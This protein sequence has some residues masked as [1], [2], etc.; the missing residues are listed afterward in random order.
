LTSSF[1]LAFYHFRNPTARGWI[2]LVV[3]AITRMYVSLFVGSRGAVIVF[4]GIFMTYFYARRKLPVRWLAIGLVTVL[5]LS[6][7]GTA[8]RN[9]LTERDTGTG[10]GFADRVQVVGES[11]QQVASRSVD[12]LFGEIRDLVGQRQASLLDITASVMFIHPSIQP[13]VGLDL[14]ES[15][16]VQLVPR[17][18]WR[19]KPTA[20]VLYDITGLYYGLPSATFSAIGLFA[21]SYRA[22]G[23]I[24]SAIIMALIGVIGAWL[25]Q[26]GP[27]HDDLA[28][29]ALYL[30]VLTRII[31]YDN[32]LASPV[33]DLLQKGIPIWLLL[34]FV[35][36]SAVPAE[37]STQPSHTTAGA[38]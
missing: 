18:L 14:L 38:K 30:I 2:W 33:L 10:V 36:F 22:G 5:I 11:L 4:L 6:P 8:I 34:K 35:M 32:S 16:V 15:L 25:Y 9:N 28:V 27:G 20:L 7:A 1:A 24:A 13:F 31:T 23:W 3:M 29:I 21:D 12:S 19:A 37:P 26:R 17:I